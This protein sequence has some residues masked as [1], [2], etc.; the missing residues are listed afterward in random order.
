MPTTVSHKIYYPAGTAVPNVP[1]QE[2]TQ[3]ESVE[4][5]L[6]SITKVPAIMLAKSN[7]HQTIG[8]V[9]V[10]TDCTWNIETHKQGIT[11]AASSASIVVSES[12]IYAINVR[13]AF[14]SATATGSIIVSVNGV[15]LDITRTDQ[16]GSSTAFA[17]PHVATQLKLNA[18]DTLKVRAQTS[19][20][21]VPISGAES[22]FQV[23]KLAVFG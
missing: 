4:S 15:D 9:Y 1:V 3:A 5:A 23:T 6:N 12:G 13:V 11:H 20:G 18:G 16:T 21:N 19:V 7:N 8:G 22:F 17:K 14:N 2:Q 10:M